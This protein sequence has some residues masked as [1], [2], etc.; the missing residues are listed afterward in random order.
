[1]RGL[2]KCGECIRHEDASAR[3]LSVV[4]IERLPYPESLVQREACDDAGEASLVTPEI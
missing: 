4:K 3:S 2:D 1:M